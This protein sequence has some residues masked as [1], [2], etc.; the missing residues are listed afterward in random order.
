MADLDEDWLARAA[1]ASESPFR[2]F[3]PEA[4]FYDPSADGLDTIE[5]YRPDGVVA[6]PAV[7]QLESARKSNPLKAAFGWLKDKIPFVEERHNPQTGGELAESFGRHVVNFGL[8]IPHGIAHAGEH[9]MSY[10]EPGWKDDPVATLMPTAP[11]AG[12]A[13]IPGLRGMISRGE[14]N[15]ISSFDRLRAKVAELADRDGMPAISRWANP[16]GDLTA[17][18]RAF[19]SIKTGSE[20]NRPFDALERLQKPANESEIGLVKPPV[21]HSLY[22]PGELRAE[23]EGKPLAAA[24][25]ARTEPL[26]MTEAVATWLRR[27][28]GQEPTV[29]PARGPHQTDYVKLPWTPADRAAQRAGHIPATRVRVPS[30]GHSHWP[31]PGVIDTAPPARRDFPEGKDL[32]RRNAGGEPYQNIDALE[33]AL[34]WATSSS[35]GKVPGTPEAN[36][37]VREDQ[38]PRWARYAKEDTQP[39]EIPTTASPD[40]ARLSTSVPF[41]ESLGEL[42][43]KDNKLSPFFGGGQPMVD[44]TLQRIEQESPGQVQRWVEAMRGVSD[45]G[46]AAF[47]RKQ[48]VQADPSYPFWKDPRWN[49]PPAGSLIDAV[50]RG[51][52]GNTAYQRYASPK[53]GATGGEAPYWKQGDREQLVRNFVEQHRTDQGRSP[54]T[55]EVRT[56]MAGHPEFRDGG[57]VPTPHA[58]SQQLYR[59]GLR[60]SRQETNTY[61]R[62]GPEALQRSIETRRRLGEEARQKGVSITGKRILPTGGAHGSRHLGEDAAAREEA[63]QAVRSADELAKRGGRPFWDEPGTARARQE[64]LDAA[65]RV[66]QEMRGK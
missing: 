60:A 10:G 19:R 13:L 31:E 53:G 48:G 37:L 32:S 29:Q 41:D 18:G 38:A 44:R 33:A 54:L 46:T 40:Q 49:S 17:Q 66:V 58:I 47:F 3:A 16:Y 43:S 1:A 9:W 11:L 45:E 2:Q 8:G 56:W 23:G 4:P 20:V 24:A 5:G 22:G 65:Q 6:H 39:T 64:D 42:W 57:R 15:P 14:G 21:G 12:A 25:G 61:N 55:A 51:G 26:P 34:K 62:P 30:D 52:S 28:T 50:N 35:P 59:M 63:S 36:W 7:Q 27:A